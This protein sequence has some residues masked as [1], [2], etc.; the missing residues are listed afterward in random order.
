MMLPNVISEA[1]AKCAMKCTV[2]F[3]FIQQA[4]K[5]DLVQPNMP[6]ASVHIWQRCI[7]LVILICELGMG[8]PSV[9]KGECCIPN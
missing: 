7:L 8:T 3:I 4:M 5:P 2:M 1:C 9:S 6:R